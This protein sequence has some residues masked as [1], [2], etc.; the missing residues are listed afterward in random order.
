MHDQE[1]Q[2]IVLTSVQAARA[3]GAPDE[4]DPPPALDRKSI[5]SAWGACAIVLVILLSFAAACVVYQL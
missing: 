4:L 2:P 5:V 1:T 3:P